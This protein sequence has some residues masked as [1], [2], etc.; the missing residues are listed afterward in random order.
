M[1]YRQF[2]LSLAA[3]V[4]RFYIETHW[5]VG[6]LTELSIHVMDLP[7][8]TVRISVGIKCNA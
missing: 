5:A 8:S 7:L 4:L 1:N 2:V 6:M 3:I